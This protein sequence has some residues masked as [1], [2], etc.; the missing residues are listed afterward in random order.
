V[1]H[2]GAEGVIRNMIYSF[3][4]SVPVAGESEDSIKYALSLFS[5]SKSS[6]LATL[7][8]ESPLIRVYTPFSVRFPVSKEPLS[9]FFGE[10]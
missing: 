4:F 6:A 10:G 8:A 5:F 3:G 1:P 2:P 9:A 7:T